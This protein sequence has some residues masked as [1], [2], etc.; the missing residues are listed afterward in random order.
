MRSRCLA[1]IGAV[2]ALA[3]ILG[4]GCGSGT[5]TADTAPFE[6]AVNTYL[7]SQSMDMKAGRFRALAV[8]DNAATATV[9][10]A[11]AHLRGCRPPTPARPSPRLPSAFAVQTVSGYVMATRHRD[12]RVWPARPE[13]TPSNSLTPSP[14][15]ASP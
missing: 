7:R 9:S 8:S 13:L 1:L 15:T 10:L 5:P 2:L 11:H 6:T 4:A 12:G 3:A 14:L